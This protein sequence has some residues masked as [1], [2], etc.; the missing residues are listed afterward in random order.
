[1]SPSVHLYLPCL[2]LPSRRPPLLLQP[3]FV[4]LCI[5]FS[6]V[7]YLHPPHPRILP[8]TLWIYPSLLSLR[9]GGRIYPFSPWIDKVECDSFWNLKSWPFSLSSLVMFVYIF[10]YFFDCHVLIVHINSVTI[11][12]FTVI[13]QHIH[14]VC[15]NCINCIAVLLK[16]YS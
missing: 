6:N 14:T 5:W 10:Y 11:E 12:R 3:L 4:N 2:W 16:K 15:T 9:N 1:L 13:F 7:F 8:F